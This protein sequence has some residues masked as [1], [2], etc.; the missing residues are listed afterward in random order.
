MT[1][2]NM[3]EKGVP[4]LSVTCEL[5]RHGA[6]LNVDAFRRFDPGSRLHPAYGLHLLRDRGRIRETESWCADRETWFRGVS[7]RLTR[8]ENNGHELLLEEVE[9]RAE[10]A[11]WRG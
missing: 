10:S 6:L 4:S 11:A 9:F 5:C 7:F 8:R 1:L 3:R 2:A